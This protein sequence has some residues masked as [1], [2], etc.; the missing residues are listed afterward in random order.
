MIEKKA[1]HVT[2]TEFYMGVICLFPLATTLVEEGIINKLLFSLLIGL[3][4]AMLFDRKVKGRTFMMLLLLIVSY[5]YSFAHTKFPL[6]NSN[7]LFYFPFYMVY[8]YFMC[9]NSRSII[10]WFL[11]SKKYI[12]G[13][14]IVWTVIV[15]FAVFLPE[16]YYVKEGGARYFRAFAGSIFRLG[17]AAVFI[18]ALAILMQTLFGSKRAFWL[19][20]LPMYSFFMG[21]SRTY[22]IVGLCLLLVSWYFF[23]SNKKKFYYSL[24][25]MA[26]GVVLLISVTSMGDK[27]A[28]TLDEDQYGDFWFRITSSRS[29]IWDYSLRY[30]KLRVPVLGKLLGAGLNFNYRITGHWAHNDFVEILGSFGIL[31][32]GQYLFS[33]Y[34]LFKSKTKRKRMPFI[35]GFS[36]IIAWLFNAFFNMHYTYFC[37]MLCYP[38]L[39]IGIKFYYSE[40]AQKQVSV[41]QKQIDEKQSID[42]K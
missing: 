10:N 3:Q 34:I 1:T 30:W 41:D 37:A 11:K 38:I 36:L 7:L 33:I 14:A 5:I 29:E 20:I 28:H 22:L 6:Q 15:G 8:T 2:L 35:V 19:N 21:S 25:P 9:D 18:Q 27:I 26:I 17:P 13:I 40:I 24:I 39:V 31:G 4:L 12:Y 23:C 16:C 42:S 32:I